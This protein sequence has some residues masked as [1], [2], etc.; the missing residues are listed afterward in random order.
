MSRMLNVGCGARWHRAWTNVDTAPLSAEVLRVDAA[1]GLPFA[2]GTFDVVYHSHVLEHLPR[3]AAGPFLA[4]C[5][6]VLRPGGT[7]RVVVPDLE[8]M[9][10][11]YL[12]AL[13]GTREGKVGAG[14]R[15]E[16]MRLELLDQLARHENGGAYAEVLGAMGPEG[17][18]F[19]LSRCGAELAPLLGAPP[20]PGRPEAASSRGLWRSLRRRWVRIQGRLLGPAWRVGTFRRS[21]QVHQ[22]MY[23]AESLGRLLLSVGLTDVRVV[24]AQQSAIEGWSGYQLDADAAG[25]VHKPD[26]LFME[27]TRR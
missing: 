5:V 14:E 15:V 13:Q 25:L 2:D 3:R 12:A 4:E 21:G 10:R 20:P 7:M 8:A 16:W 24:S 6:R 23:D 9:A 11:E 22:W 17:R 19:A 27:A 26:S 1:R 18:Q